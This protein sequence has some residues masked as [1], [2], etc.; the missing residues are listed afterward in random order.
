M[1]V[2]YSTMTTQIQNTEGI[3][4]VLR[5]LHWNGQVTHAGNGAAIDIWNNSAAV[6]LIQCLFTNVWSYSTEA[7]PGYGVVHFAIADVNVTD[8]QFYNCC[9]KDPR[10]TGVGGGVVD[11]GIGPF[12]VNVSNCHFERCSSQNPGGIIYIGSRAQD[13]DNSM[14]VEHTTFH[15][16]YVYR[17]YNNQKTL[18]DSLIVCGRITNFIFSFNRVTWSSTSENDRIS[19]NSV[20]NFSFANPQTGSVVI[21]NCYVNN[22]QL[23]NGFVV[24]NTEAL[25]FTYLNMVI[26]SVDCGD[27]KHQSAFLPSGHAIQNVIFEGCRFQ[28][29]ST[30]RAFIHPE[31]VTGLTHLRLLDTTFSQC[32]CNNG[33]FLDIKNVPNVEILGCLFGNVRWL[34]SFTQSGQM[35][36]VLFDNCAKVTI[37]DITFDMPKIS[38]EKIGLS[39]KGGDYFLVQRCTFSAIQSSQSQI[40]FGD[41]VVTRLED[42]VFNIY[43]P[44]SARILSSM[45]PL[46]TYD[47]TTETHEFQFYKCCFQHDKDPALVIDGSGMY[48]GLKGQGT[49]VYNRSCFDTSRT[50]ALREEGSISI[51]ILGREEDDMF[52]GCGCEVFLDEPT[53]ETLV[54]DG[55]TLPP[56]PTTGVT[57]PPASSATPV[58]PATEVPETENP[59]VDGG[60]GQGQGGS[61]SK[62]KNDLIGGIIGGL[63][64][65]L[66]LL[67]FLLLLLRKKKKSSS[68]PQSETSGVGV[69]PPPAELPLWAQPPSEEN[70]NLDDS[71]E[72][73][74]EGPVLTYPGP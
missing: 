22:M 31:Y 42:S 12:Y 14:I 15:D 67:L 57:V 34:D 11:L 61:D 40:L 32:R 63:L 51:E 19:V 52:G 10:L 41:S 27:D 39:L 54:P 47:G 5:L 56:T 23:P 6:D 30:Q 74:E 70:P 33:A 72:E 49:V 44:T 48:M 68:E 46:V 60:A 73:E 7:D 25:S 55:Q 50:N 21:D 45:E 2:Q 3:S 9:S 43:P 35:F 69:A 28:L 17:N 8:C 53:F 16:C 24:L 18:Y 58:I 1:E 64:L 59:D 65:L 4:T 62:G 36:L 38:L 26:D 20:M 66:L 29:C 71:F 37:A 13:K